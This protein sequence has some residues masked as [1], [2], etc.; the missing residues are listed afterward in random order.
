[1]TG[2]GRVLNGIV[3]V[4]FSLSSPARMRVAVNL[5]FLPLGSGRLSNAP[6]GVFVGLASQFTQGGRTHSIREGRDQSVWRLEEPSEPSELHSEQAD[7]ATTQY[8]D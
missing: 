2:D 8:N 1:M 3:T 6:F 4:S 5:R 7:N